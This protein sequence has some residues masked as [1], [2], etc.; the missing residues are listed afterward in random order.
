V[1][2]SRRRR[3][4]SGRGKMPCHIP[5]IC[6][7]DETVDIGAADLQESVTDLLFHPIPVQLPYQYRDSPGES[8]DIHLVV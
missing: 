5:S 8:F 7:V 2:W 1:A 6:L 4:L 3:H